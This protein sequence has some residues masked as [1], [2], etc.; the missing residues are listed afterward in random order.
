MKNRFLTILAAT[1]AIC[2]PAA[3]VASGSAP[4]RRM[5]AKKASPAAPATDARYA[6]GQQVYGGTAPKAA[7][8]GSMDSQKTR[9][10]KIAA[11]VPDMNKGKSISA[12]AGKLSAEQLDALEYFVSVR[13]PK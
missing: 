6:I 1:L 2:A 9:L 10:A 11:A 8:P 12:L 7:N 3:A 5:P 4:A 13:F